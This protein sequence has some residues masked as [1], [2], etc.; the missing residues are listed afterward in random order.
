MMYP[1]QREKVSSGRLVDPI[2]KTIGSGQA[3][4]LEQAY[5]KYHYVP[6][7]LP[8]IQANDQGKFVQWYFDISAPAVK[9]THNLANPDGVG[10]NH[11]RTLNSDS[12]DNEVWTKKYAPEIFKEFPELKEQILE[13]FPITKLNLWRM[14]SS[15]AEILNHRD[16][17]SL[18]D[19]PAAIRVKLY[20]ENPQ[21]TLWIREDD[22]P[23]NKFVLPTLTDTNSFA[24][25]NLRVYHGSNYNPEYKKILWIITLDDNL[26]CNKYVDLMD[27][28]ISKYK[29]LIIADHRPREYYYD[30]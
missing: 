20:E 18:I 14:W 26:N 4:E 6:F 7:D 15:T 17:D 11:F 3:E 27:R 29:N 30:L 16:D 21:E 5:G 23:W 19:C 2:R 10:N 9:K 22:E 8:I 28:S 1:G 24:W 13:Y 25:N 12:A